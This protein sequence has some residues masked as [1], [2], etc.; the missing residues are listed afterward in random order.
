MLFISILQIMIITPDCQKY[1]PSFLKIFLSP[2]HVLERYSVS[3]AD[4]T[5]QDETENGER[6]TEDRAMECWSTGGFE[7]W[8][9]ERCS[10]AFGAKQIGYAYWLRAN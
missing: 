4:P 10:L 5:D 7:Y 3:V 9:T 6:R 1:H 8:S 2:L